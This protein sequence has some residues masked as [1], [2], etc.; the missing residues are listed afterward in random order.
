MLTNKVAIVTGGTRGIGLAMVKALLE[1]GATVVLAGSREET[2]NKAVEGIK[3]EN[4]DAKVEGIWPD[5]TKYEDVKACFDKIYEKYGH[6][7]ILCNNAGVSARDLIEDTTQ[8]MFEKVIDIN[9]IAVFNCSKAAYE[10]MMVQKS[11]CIINTSSMVSQYGQ[12]SGLAYPTSKFAIN[13][14]TLSLAREGAKYGIRVNAVAPGVTNTDMVKA[15]PEDMREKLKASLPLGRMGEPEDIANAVVFL[16][17]DHAS[18]ISG[19]T[20]RVDGLATV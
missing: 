2:A 10:H 11:G 17:S 20:I 14:L 5:L 18:Y 7:D 16:A 8:E 3:A 1:E 19:Q 12:P 15:L 13:G 9:V 6:I 4:P